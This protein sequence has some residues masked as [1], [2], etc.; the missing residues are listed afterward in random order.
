[1]KKFVCL[2]VA[3]FLSAC[4]NRI[5]KREDQTPIVVG[6]AGSELSDVE[7]NCLCKYRPIGV[8]LF[9]KNC[10]NEQQL[11][12]LTTEIKKFGCIVF[13]DIEGKLINRLSDFFQIDKDQRDFEFADP[14]EV[15]EYYYKIAR[16]VKS[17]GID[18]VFA[19]VT[20]VSEA[21]NSAACIGRRSFA[22]D[23]VKVANLAYEV[24]KAYQDNGITP[25]IKHL[26]GHGKAEVD[27]HTSLPIVYEDPKDDILA[28]AMLI[29]KLKTEGR[30]LPH[31]MT[32]HV[33]YKRIDPNFPA[34][35]SPVVIQKVIRNQ[36]GLNDGLVFSDC[37]K[38]KALSRFPRSWE[39][40]Y[41]SGGNVIV[42]CDDFEYIKNNMPSILT[43][44]AQKRYL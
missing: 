41:N 13:I 17:C 40:F 24:V 12:A 43:H 4:T 32:A 28:N 20:D 7:K 39:Q 14:K 25:I 2:V 18:A 34:T 31:C 15:Y 44:R 1:M 35:L 11:K 30:Q 16:Y 38:M 19:P 27:S 37:F 26:P 21:S 36:I 5:E 9:K 33:V 22:N 6:I 29:K 3:I 8:I 23:P 10:I 42:I